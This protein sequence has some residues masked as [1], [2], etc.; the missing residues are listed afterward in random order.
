MVQPGPSGARL[1]LVVKEAPWLADQAVFAL[2]PGLR[3]VEKRSGTNFWAVASLSD[4]AKKGR[5]GFH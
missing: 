1:L 2:K 3:L 4:A 5:R